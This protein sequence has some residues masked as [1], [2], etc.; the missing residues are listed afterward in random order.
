M[1]RVYG[2]L[3]AHSRI[4]VV[5]YTSVIALG[6][7]TGKIA[8]SEKIERDDWGR[9]GPD[10]CEFVAKGQF[11]LRERCSPCVEVPARFEGVLRNV[12]WLGD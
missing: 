3:T 2:F 4:M 8:A 7:T 11:P 1:R 5:L 10:R 9:E 6:S 12:R